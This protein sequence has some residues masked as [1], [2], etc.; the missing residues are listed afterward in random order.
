MTLVGYTKEEL[1]KLEKRLK[2]LKDLYEFQLE[3]GENTNVTDQKIQEL[4]RILKNH[5]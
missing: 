2:Q 1:E 5:G 4:E 3:I